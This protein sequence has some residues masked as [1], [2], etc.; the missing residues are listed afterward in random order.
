M[1]V[2]GALAAT[3]GVASS[4]QKAQGFV[5]PGA[6]AGKLLTGVNPA[7][8]FAASGLSAP[9]RM[10]ALGAAV[11]DP[12]AVSSNLPVS[13]TSAL[14]GISTTALSAQSSDAAEHSQEANL[15]QNVSGKSD[16]I[17]Q[18]A[19]ALIQSSKS[20]SFGLPS[21]DGKSTELSYAPFTF[22]DQPMRFYV[23]GSPI[24]SASEALIGSAQTGKP[25]A[26]LFMAPESE[27]RQM[28]ART[29][30]ALQVHAKPVEKGSAEWQEQIGKLRERYGKIVETLSAMPD[31]AMV[32]LEPFEGR[33]IKGFG[34]AYDLVGDDLM[35]SQ[36]AMG[37]H[38]SGGAK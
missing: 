6:G 4:L 5:Q 15:A 37:D 38:K 32:S 29:R 26:V 22:E 14:Q 17:A 13:R 2:Y 1:N 35:Q 10:D 8:S 7:G 19:R 3:L 27:T 28:Y 12:R 11:N 30:L 18:E 25:T 23:L 33:F 20:L 9:P 34:Q 31:F 21:V 36:P 24:A 16:K